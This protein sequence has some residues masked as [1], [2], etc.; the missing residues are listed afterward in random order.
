MLLEPILEML[1]NQKFA[2][3]A[4]T[5]SRVPGMELGLG[6]GVGMVVG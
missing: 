2:I 1:F 3:P 4:R 5:A 6:T